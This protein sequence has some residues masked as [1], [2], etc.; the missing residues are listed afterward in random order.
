VGRALAILAALA[1]ARC[2]REPLPRY[3][4]ESDPGS[5]SRAE[6]VRDRASG[7]W[8]YREFE[9]RVDT[10][11]VLPDPMT[12]DAYG[13][14]LSLQ[15]FAPGSAKTGGLR[16]GLPR[17]DRGHRTW[18]GADVIGRADVEGKV[19]YGVT[20]S[21]QRDGEPTRYDPMEVFPLPPLG[22]TEPGAWSDWFSAATLREGAF[23][24]WNEVH[25]RPGES[26]PR[27]DHP[28]EFRWRLLLEDTPGR[29]P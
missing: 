12:D 9:L 7:R 3:A 6:Y 25:R 19:A 4:L 29:V 8:V 20:I 11:R 26:L 15:H 2:A 17:L 16:S 1:G 13:D 21:W 27:P 24:W 23:G 14:R 28:F 18:S 5:R 10:L 22:A